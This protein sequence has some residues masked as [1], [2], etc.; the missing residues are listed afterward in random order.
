MSACYRQIAVLIPD[1]SPSE[2]RS[3]MDII[4]NLLQEGFSPDTLVKKGA[5]AKYVSAVC[6]EI[7]EGTKRRK[8]LWLAPKPATKSIAID[9]P[10]SNLTTTA[11][12]DRLSQ[13]PGSD[14]EVSISTNRRGSLS[15]EGSAEFQL[16]ENPSPPPPRRIRHHRLVPSSSWVP[17]PSSQPIVTTLQ[18]TRA[19]KIESYKPTQLGTKV[20]PTISPRPL[21]ASVPPPTPPPPAAQPLLAPSLPRPPVIN[22]PSGPSRYNQTT[23]SGPKSMPSRKKGKKKNLDE[24]ATNDAPITLNYDE[25]VETPPS[26]ARSGTSVASAIVVDAQSSQPLHQYTYASSRPPVQD[27]YRPPLPLATSSGSSQPIT[28][29][30]QTEIDGKNAMLEIRR[31]ALESMRK[32]KLAKTGSPEKMEVDLPTP[33][34]NA[35]PIPTP[36]A[37]ERTIEQE[38]L[39]LEQEVMGLQEAED[40]RQE[41]EIEEEETSRPRS[42]I[43]S[44]VDEEIPM[45]LDSPEPGEIVSTL[46]SALPVPIAPIPLLPSSASSLPLSRR[47]VKRPNAED[48]ESRPLSAPSW[49]RRKPFGGAVQRPNRL[50]INLDEMSESDSDDDTQYRAHTPVVVANVLIQDKEEQIRLLREKIA[51]RLKEKQAKKLRTGAASESPS[52]APEPAGLPVITPEVATCALI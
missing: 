10:Q 3:Y 18:P 17:T 30:A 15:S 42:P 43:K 44:L 40:A 1:I 4:R 51:A 26:T 21:Q 23:A 24:V 8:A 7:V 37:I 28:S 20:T 33:T 32:R 46:S 38:V 13:S 35:T 52:P 50:M 11:A 2:A 47:G 27:R 34:D 49:V 41:E 6:E 31:K 16:I 25:D 19:V 22:A 29:A 39:D 12:M 48:M 5:T 36:G 45:E 14:I 9:T